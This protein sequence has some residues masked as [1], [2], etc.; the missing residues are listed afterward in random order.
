MDSR[1]PIFLH[2][3]EKIITTVTT[4]TREIKRS[5]G[6]KITKE[7]QK[8]ITD[9]DWIADTGRT[10]TQGGTKW[11]AIPLI[12]LTGHRC[13]VVEVPPPGYTITTNPRL[14]EAL[15]ESK[16]I[17]A[18]PLEVALEEMMAARIAAD[19]RV[20]AAN[21]AV[22]AA[23]AASAAAAADVA[24]ATAALA[25]F[26]AETAA[27]EAAETVAFEERIAAALAAAAPADDEPGD[28]CELIPGIDYEIEELN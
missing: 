25:A 22:A 16:R 6:E 7:A 21:A 15:R 20:V 2:R 11:F 13:W 9:G 8:V 19:P 4:C 10:F 23:S 12:T 28:P 26:D 5:R 18:L 27:A 14:V 17:K 1:S 24:D 3:G